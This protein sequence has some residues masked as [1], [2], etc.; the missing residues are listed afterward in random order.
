MTSFTYSTGPA[1]VVFGSG[2][3]ATLPDEVAQLG[4]SRVLLIGSG[5]ARPADEALGSL[6]AARFDGAVM[7][8]PVDVTGKAL[9]VLR[10]HAADCLVAVGGG[11]AIGLAKALAL[12]TGLPQIA[13]PTT[14]AGSEATPVLGQTA[15]GAK[16]TVRDPEVLPE[17]IVYDVDLTVDLP[18]NLSVTS[19]INAMA[20][21]VEALYSPGA[22]PVADQQALDAIRRLA[23][24]LPRIAADPADR[25]ARDD[26]LIAAWLA[27]TCLGSVQMGLHHKLAHVLGGKFGLPHSETHT[28]LLPHVM[29]AMAPAAMD[30]VAD[31][32]GVS[33]A[34]TGVYDLV[35]ALGG[36][37][38][39]REL[40]L[41]EAD[42][43]QV[44]DHQALLRQAWEGNRPRQTGLPDTRALTKQVVDSF[45]GGEPRT[46]ALL[47][48][49]VR[50]MHS[51]V[52]RNDLTEAEWMHAVTFL[53]RT[54]QISGDTRQ[55][56]IL[57]S[58]TLGVSS[59]VDVL[60]NSRTPDTTPSA[61]LGPFYTEGPPERPHGFDIADGLPGNP[62]W[63][64]IQVADTH[65]KPVAD[66]IVD[67]WQSNEDGYYDVQLP[68]LDGPVLRARFRTDA[69]GRLRFWSIV[70]ASYPIP[71]DGPVGQLLAA[72][73][74]HPNRA[75]H[76]HFMIAKPGFHTLVTQLFVKGGDYL[77]S[78][79]VF[80]V[81]DGLIVDFPAQ[82]GPT[83][84]GRD[85]SRWSRVDFVFRISEG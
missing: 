65:D 59:V 54:G 31:A 20:H 13:V 77:D 75:P 79:T 81:K 61:V 10:D 6:V 33:D 7:H 51:Y 85:V 82:Q 9:A 64:D 39:L 2:T 70:P 49:L 62:L 74:R 5:R 37:T 15:D 76:V 58:D 23:R 44:D 27:G 68:D 83:P 8:T 48:D 42:L 28:V 29:A 53:T 24:A 25:S 43:A 38:S 69:D 78:D 45:S 72:V 41:T 40:G 12:R 71:A 26:A 21:A 19:G 1:R 14:Y 18:V 50:T 73:G 57:L 35:V 3:V 56:F 22:N 84:D 46:R 67:V 17:T 30:R 47:Q 11:S 63:A 80:G 52:L 32:L 36:P 60:T 4:A 34:P 66:A 16:T 55:E